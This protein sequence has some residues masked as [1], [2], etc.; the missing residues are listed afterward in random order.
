M[1]VP[2]VRILKETGCQ[3]YSKLEG[4]MLA[5]WICRIESL[6]VSNIIIITVILFFRGAFTKLHTRITIRTF[7]PGRAQGIG[8]ALITSDGGGGEEAE[9]V[10][11]GCG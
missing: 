11:V 6:E 3:S 5:L 9:H 10:E 7:A 2:K 8:N 4:D 1:R